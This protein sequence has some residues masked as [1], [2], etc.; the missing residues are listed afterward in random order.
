MT[1]HDYNS[2]LSENGYNL[3]MPASAVGIRWPII[4]PN[5]TV[6]SRNKAI[7]NQPLSS[8]SSLEILLG[9]FSGFF[10]AYGQSL[11]VGCSL[12]SLRLDQK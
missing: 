12:D 2:R 11:P 4:R 5:K 7:A 9:R 8:S 3:P 6:V 10:D 1:G